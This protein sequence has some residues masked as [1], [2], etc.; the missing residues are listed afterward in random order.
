VR[1]LYN[2]TNNQIVAWWGHTPYPIAAKHAIDVEPVVAEAVLKH[3]DYKDLVDITDDPSYMYDVNTG[4]TLKKSGD[5][6]TVE[7][8]TVKVDSPKP[9]DDE[10]WDPNFASVDDL[11]LYAIA[12]N[13]KID[14]AVSES[15]LRDIVI[16]H[17]M[18]SF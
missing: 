10:N 3:G 9:W 8:D 6:T 1:K 13:L 5:T 17:M 14:A 4:V 7:V 2:P 12:F 16:E 15:I 18:D 11:K